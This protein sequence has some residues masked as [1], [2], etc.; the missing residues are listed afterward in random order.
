[1]S[2]GRTGRKFSSLN[3]APCTYCG[4]PMTR[5]GSPAQMN[6]ATR[7]HVDAASRGGTLK[8]SVRCCRRCNEDKIHLSLNEWRAALCW[9]HKHLHV[10]YF[11][12]LQFGLLWV[13]A[14]VVAHRVLATIGF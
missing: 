11:E 5:T 3:G 2:S 10:F 1:M 12:R 4:E 14:G 6:F 13:Q 7:D 9:R 8:N